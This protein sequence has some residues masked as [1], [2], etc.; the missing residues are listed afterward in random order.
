MKNKASGLNSIN[1]TFN[2]SKREPFYNWYNFIQGYSPDF[3]KSIIKN[4]MPDAKKILDPFG[5]TVTTGFVSIELNK[6][7]FYCEINP[8]LNFIADV[9]SRVRILSSEEKNVMAKKIIKL[10]TILP[11]AIDIKPADETLNK[12]YQE[13]FKNSKFFDSV[14]FRK[15]LISRTLIN[16]IYKEDKLLSDLLCVAVLS[17]LIPS[18]LMKLQ[19]DLRYKTTTELKK[20]VPDFI[21]I[22]ENKLKAMSKDISNDKLK[23]KKKPILVCENAKDLDKINGLFFD[24]VITSPPYL[25]GTN[26]FRNTKLELWFLGCLKTK[27]DLKNY[28]KMA[29]TAGINDVQG[30]YKIPVTYALKNTIKALEEKA[31]DKRIPKMVSNYFSEIEDIFLK[32]KKHLVKNTKLAIDIGDSEYAGI[33]IQ[34]DKFLIEILKS[35]GYKHLSTIKLRERFSKNNDKLTQVLLIFEN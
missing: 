28:R 17:S 1:S 35:I 24:G 5:G 34:T 6:N 19:G 11:K 31:Y 23:L 20:I 14:T 7:G 25:N 29:L 21:Q 26:Y 30:E 33:R 4:Y 12:T 27:D 2:G 18:S 13:I 8:V 15:V 3:V 10:S 22:L 16:D 32:L 9:K